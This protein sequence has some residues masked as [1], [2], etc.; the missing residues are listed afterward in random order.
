MACTVH[1]VRCSGSSED[2][3]LPVSEMARLASIVVPFGLEPVLSSYS[4]E[5]GLLLRLVAGRN[6]MLRIDRPAPPG[7][8][9]GGQAQNDA[10]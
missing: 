2:W 6:E 7:G 10:N 5:G 8:Q 3:G 4:D 9:K 1:V